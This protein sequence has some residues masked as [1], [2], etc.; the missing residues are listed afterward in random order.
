MRNTRR[1]GY[2]V[3][4]LGATG[5]VGRAMVQTLER[6]NFPVSELKLF[7]TEKSA[8]TRIIFHGEEILVQDAGSGHFADTDIFLFSA[9]SEAARLYAK[10]AM[11]SGAVVIDNSSAFR[12]ETW[13]PLV[14][15]EVNPEAISDHRGLISNPNCS[16]IQLTV[17][18]KP[19][20]S[21]GMEHVYVST[22]QAASGM[23]QKGITGLLNGQED[24]MTFPTRNSSKHYPLVL[25][26]LPQCDD[27]TANGYTK[28]EMKI[29]NESRKILGRKDLKISPTAVRVPV[30]YGHSESVAIRFN[31]Q[32]SLSEIRAR[33]SK[34]PGIII[35]DDPEKGVIPHPKMAEGSGDVYVG[36]IRRDITDPNTIMMFVV[37][38][39]ILKGA[40]WNAVQIAEILVNRSLFCQHDPTKVEG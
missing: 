33:L 1:D 15:P 20:L 7:A 6:R 36:R 31:H 14:V 22:Y 34:A 40:S 29:V 18:I 39:N 2:T 13:V 32:V 19:L 5:V 27:F 35:A 4:V 12:M 38:D 10:S 17:A 16:T 28:E 9:G 8:G 3:A 11:D 21:L 37:A 25:N 30:V 24:D 26:V 23:G